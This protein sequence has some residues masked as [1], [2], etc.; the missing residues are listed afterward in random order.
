MFLV[1][2]HLEGL[3]A[4][5]DVYLML[6]LKAARAAGYRLDIVFT[7]EESFCNRPFARL[8]PG[9]AAIATAHWPRA[10]RLGAWFW[11]LSPRVWARSLGRICLEALRRCGAPIAI[12]SRLGDV[13]AQ[14]D[15]AAAAR[16]IE[17]LRPD[18]VVADYSSLAPV[19]ALTR[20]A[21]VRAV[22]LHDLFSRRAHAFRAAGR[23]P[24]HTEMSLEDEA[25]RVANATHLFYASRDE[26]T[27]FAPLTQR[28][29]ALWMRPSVSPKRAA[30]RSQA[31]MAVFVGTNHAGNRD[32]LQHLLEDIW[33]LV[34]QRMPQARL[35]IVGRIS[36]TLTAPLPQ[37]VTAEG[38]AADLT[39]LAGP[40]LVGLAPTRLASGISIK[41][42]DYLALG[43]PVVSYP[44][45]VEGF[46]DALAGGVAIAR[47]PETFA[48]D[49]AALL[50]D[51]GLRRSRSDAGLDLVERLFSST[52]VEEAFAGTDNG[53]GA[54]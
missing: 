25:A 34:L 5:N 2:R 24:D 23:Q 36:E 30:R 12:R 22:I 10:V 29:K 14:A 51:A 18:V 48:A 28:Q 38:P 52:G 1:H 31:P 50:G 47:T 40:D 11:S 45:G 7:P 49:V 17:D 19:F 46:G 54:P 53:G 33:P 3:T 16:M 41:V 43:Q 20:S 4:G 8:A 39:A 37:G 9:F 15:L 35:R 44:A 13:P 21:R 6:C 42:A 27:A 26:M 32:A